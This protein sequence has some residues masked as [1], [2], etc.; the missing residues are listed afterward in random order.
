MQNQFITCLSITDLRK[1]LTLYTW[2]THTHFVMCRVFV[3]AYKGFA[4]HT[5]TAMLSGARNQCGL[6]C[7]AISISKG[8]PLLNIHQHSMEMC[9][10][11]CAR[12]KSIRLSY[13][14]RVYHHRYNAIN[15]EVIRCIE[16]RMKTAPRQDEDNYF[17]WHCAANNARAE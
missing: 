15:S 14:A 10:V 3:S 13:G 9:I 12:P 11:W 8:Q 2:N 16:F 6:G 5:W 4:K 7:G 17:D 1:D